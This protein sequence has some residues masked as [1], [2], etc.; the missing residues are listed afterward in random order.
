VSKRF[1][2]HT[3]E[4]AFASL[5]RKKGKDKN[6]C[7]NF[8]HRSPHVSMWIIKLQIYTHTLRRKNLSVSV[9]TWVKSLSARWT[10]TDLLLTYVHAFLVPVLRSADMRKIRAGRD[11]AGQLGA[12]DM[13]AFHI[14]HAAVVARDAR[15]LSALVTRD[16]SGTMWDLGA[17][18]FFREFYF[19]HR[20]CARVRVSVFMWKNSRLYARYHRREKKLARCHG[21]FQGKYAPRARTF[22]ALARRRSLAEY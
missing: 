13:P 18:A 3:K 19:T 22:C 4:K 20:W 9:A 12:G 11:R 2:F 10:W 15:I 16:A 8:I 6:R 14:A 7:W 21:A 5:S 1:F 17:R